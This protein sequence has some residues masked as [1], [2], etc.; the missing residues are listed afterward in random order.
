MVMY[1]NLAINFASDMCFYDIISTYE[2]ATSGDQNTKCYIV[3]VNSV[4]LQLNETW[5]LSQNIQN[6]SA[7]QNQNTPH[8]WPPV[9]IFTH[10][11]D[12]WF[13]HTLLQIYD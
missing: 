5:N 9:Q 11:L 12:N 10:S 7:K 13:P 8:P 3:E 6:V 2:L 1:I 4:S